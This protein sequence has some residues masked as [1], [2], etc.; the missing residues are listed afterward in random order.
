[1]AS[2]IKESFESFRTPEGQKGFVT[3]LLIIITILTA[4]SWIWSIQFQVYSGDAWVS[5]NPTQPI[6]TFTSTQGTEYF[7]YITG[8]GEHGGSVN[9]TV[10]EVNGWSY[11]GTFYLGDSVSFGNWKVQITQINL[12]RAKPVHLQW[13]S[14]ADGRP[15]LTLIFV[16]L[17]IVT[18]AFWGA[19]PKRKASKKSAKP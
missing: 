10:N 12:D 15:L 4:Y 9:V 6:W 16:I 11:S 2:W 8:I 7:F 3:A 17:L 19:E 5:A 14:Y 13:A 1:M 18:L